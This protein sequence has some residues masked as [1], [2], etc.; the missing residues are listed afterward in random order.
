MDRI[1]LS[2]RLAKLRLAGWLRRT[3]H[4]SIDDGEMMKERKS[5]MFGKSAISRDLL[6]AQN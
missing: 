6:C 3:R 4:T 1:S 2:R 5:K